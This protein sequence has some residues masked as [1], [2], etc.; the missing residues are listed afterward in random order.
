MPAVED[1]LRAEL[2]RVAETVQQ[3][4]LRTLRE[5]ARGSARRR[6]LLPVIAAA[7]A[8]VVTIVAA[9]LAS[10][11]SGQR[12]FAAPRPGPAPMPRYYVTVA[13]TST[14]LDAVVRDSA[15]GTVTGSVPLPGTFAAAGQSVTASPDGRTFA[16]AANLISAKTLPGTV[17]MLYFW[18]PVSADGHPGTPA[19]LPVGTG[20]AEPLTGMALSPDGAMLA[21]SLERF[22]FTTNIAPYGDVEVINLATGKIRTWTG[23][24]QPGYHPGA[25]T[26]GNDGR[27]LTFPWWHITSQTTGAAV[28]TGVRELD[29][30]APGSNLLASRLTG[31]PTATENLQSAVITSDGHDIVASSCR[32][33]DHD[34]AVARIVELSAADGQL[35]RVLRTQTTRFAN[36][37]DEQ[38]A[39]DESCAVLSVDA[40]GQHA[41]VQA[42]SFGRID[43]GVFTALPGAPPSS[44]LFA[45][46]AW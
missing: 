3:G 40:T 23:H 43:N 12:G 29:T 9:V 31:F 21:L 15:N 25:P 5:P 33:G 19:E 24:S 34:T 16:I 35:V 26:W 7:A 44:V 30:A 41:L 17:A 45:A 46:A 18:L 11:S 38:D 27:T 1:Q 42:F 22:G 2:T 14:V 32:G 6:R 13:R 20:N 39:L 36:A 37:T 10:G 4:Q 28:I 8:T